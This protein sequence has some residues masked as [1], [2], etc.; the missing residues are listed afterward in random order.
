MDYLSRTTSPILEGLWAQID[1]AAVGVARNVLIGRRFLHLTGPLGIGVT[2]IQI[3]DAVSRTEAL[4]DG[5]VINKGRRVVEIPTLYEDF[6]LLARDL[7]LSEAANR[8][9]RSGCGANRGADRRHPRRS[10][11]LFGEPKTRH[12]GS[13]DRARLEPHQQIRLDFG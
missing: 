10:T 6:T 12:R 4:E 2:S 9:R 11:D 7:A 13:A 5:F 3:D 8:P 1:A